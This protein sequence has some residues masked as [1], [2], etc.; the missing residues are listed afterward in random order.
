MAVVSLVVSGLIGLFSIVIAILQFQDRR[1]LSVLEIQRH[2]TEATQE[3]QSQARQVSCWVAS[4]A[5][6]NGA[7]KAVLHLLNSAP[8][9]IFQVHVLIR[10]YYQPYEPA[11]A[12]EIGGQFVGSLGPGAELL[13]DFEI[14]ADQQEAFLASGSLPTEVAFLD[15]ARR[16]WRRTVQ[17]E[18]EELEHLLGGFC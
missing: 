14:H 5:S 12:S 13:W 11:T 4:T 6:E 18:L 2:L 7:R 16:Q 1:R 10:P 17:G 3:R 8:Q 15:V 9:P